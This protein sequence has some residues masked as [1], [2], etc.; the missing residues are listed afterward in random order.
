MN[1]RGNNSVANEPDSPGSVH[2]LPHPVSQHLASP[3]QSWS[4]SHSNSQI[5]NSWRST[6]GH[7]PDFGTEDANI[8]IEHCNARS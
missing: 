5:D 7:C 1:I 6:R 8:N 2:S 3:A 4:W